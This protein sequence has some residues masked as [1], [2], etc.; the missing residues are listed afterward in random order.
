MQNSELPPVVAIHPPST[1][2]LAIGN[3]RFLIRSTKSNRQN[4]RR[5]LL[6]PSLHH[7]LYQPHEHTIQA[8]LI[9]TPTTPSMATSHGM[10]ISQHRMA[11]VVGYLVRQVHKTTPHGMSKITT[12]SSHFAVAYLSSLPEAPYACNKHKL[13]IRYHQHTP[14]LYIACGRNSIIPQSKDYACMHS[15]HRW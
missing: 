9:H 15:Y 8:S 4:K 5:L 2:R 10:S 3:M 7:L 1:I 11:Y 6:I 13:F 12:S 14:A